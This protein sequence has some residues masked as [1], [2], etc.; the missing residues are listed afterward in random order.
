MELFRAQN[1]QFKTYRAS[2]AIHRAKAKQDIMSDIDRITEKQDA[3]RQ[4]LLSSLEVCTKS[5]SMS[6][7][8]EDVYAC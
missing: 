5:E 7:C 6:Q 8:R 3:G 4:S 1:E 2:M